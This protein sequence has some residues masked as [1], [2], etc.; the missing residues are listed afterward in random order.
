MTSGKGFFPVNG[1]PYSP[2]ECLSNVTEPTA[3]IKSFSHGARGKLQRAA[4]FAAAL[5]LAACTTPGSPVGSATSAKSAAPAGALAALRR[6]DVVWLQRLTFGLDSR[7]LGD[8]RRLGRERYLDQQL[9]PRD[10]PLPE[11]VAAQLRA[12]EV[13][14]TDPAGA[15]GELHERRRSINAMSEGADQDQARKALNEEGN[16]L[17]YRAVRLQLLRALY[18]PAQLRE[19]M[20]WFWLNHFSV[21]QHKADERW[22]L[23]DY[24]ERAI[25]PHA[26]G[27]FRDLV[28]AT[29]EH[30]AMLEYLDNAQNA[31]GHVNENY[32]RE[33][34]ELHTLGVDGGYGQQDVPQLARVLTGVGI[35]TAAAP[36]LRRESQGLYVRHGAFEFNPAR[37][38][39]G[40][41]MLLGQRIDGAGFAEVARAVTLIVRRPACAHFISRELATYFAG[42]TPPTEL[43]DAMAGT[44]RRTD[45]DIAAT[46]RTLF[47]SRQLTALPASKFK[48]PM[49]YVLSAVRLAYDGRTITNTRPLLDWLNALGEAPFGRATPDGYPLT[50]PGWESPGQM[51]RRFEIA[52]AIGSGNVHLFDAED[53]GAA[54]TNRFPQLSNR[55]YYEAI[56]PFLAANTRSALDQAGSPQEWNT[57]LL[58]SPE[59]N[60]E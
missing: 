42:D 28:L 32:A 21:H 17:A 33:L 7:T 16:R 56:E 6:E 35:D 20:V 53:T 4:P 19:Q 40:A 38:D 9:H 36:H 50:G 24:A 59:M 31:V 52:R 30:P 55:L 8:Y 14:Q 3:V 43:I 60:Y 46:L 13:P 49:R 22:L 47:L 39:F 58:A 54:T 51:S 45:G 15:L 12:L 34:M 1:A 37:H 41:K 57:F 27:R 29:L 2:L 26:L 25:R 18:S 10:D 23:G 48:D 11:P 44:F 5:A